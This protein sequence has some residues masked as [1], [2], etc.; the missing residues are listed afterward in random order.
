MNGVEERKKV[1]TGEALHREC[2]LFKHYLPI[3]LIY[4]DIVLLLQFILSGKANTAFF[5][6]P[7]VEKQVLIFEYGSFY[8]FWLQ[9]QWCDVEEVYYST[10]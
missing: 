9:Y 10:S 8:I 1:N 5:T 4:I 6:V 3:L 7:G 2:H